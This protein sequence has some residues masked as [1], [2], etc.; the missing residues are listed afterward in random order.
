M[1]EVGKTHILTIANFTAFGAYLDAGTGNRKDNIL[2]PKKQVPPEIKEGD[3]IEVFIYRDSEDRIIA[4]T[5]KP[6]AEI[7]EL[8]YL[9]VT[10]NTKL[11]AFLDFGLE[12]GLFLPYSEQRYPLYIGKSYLV[13]LYLDKSGRICCTTDIYKHLSSA[14]PYNKNDQVT[15]TVYFKKPEM[16]VF[17]AV[18]DKYLGLIPNNEYFDDLEIGDIIQARV[19]RVREDG[20]LDLSTKELSHMQMTKDSKILYDAMLANNG[21]LPYDEKTN[22]EVIQRKFKMSKAAYKRAIGGLLKSKKV[23]KTENGFKIANEIINRKTTMITRK[24]KR[25]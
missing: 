20:K 1:I 25:K 6:Y 9:K 12:R 2:L 17:V 24:F 15:G 10:A 19:I 18:D 16:G 22:P 21:V 3:P 23:T 5:T 7:G 4:T 11:G 14:A 8:A 13:F